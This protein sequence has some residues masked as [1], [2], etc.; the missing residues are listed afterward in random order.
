[1][2]LSNRAVVVCV[3]QRT[4]MNHQNVSAKQHSSVM[5]QVWL[6]IIWEPKKLI[7]DITLHL[8][9]KAIVNTLEIAHS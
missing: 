3:T 9:N 4:Q 7:A 1:M 8:L 5:Q 2:P 6:L